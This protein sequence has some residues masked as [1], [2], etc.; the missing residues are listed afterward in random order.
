MIFFYTIQTDLSIEFDVH[1]NKIGIVSVNESLDSESTANN[2]TI[3]SKLD[4]S[5]QFPNS[6]YNH[7]KY[8]NR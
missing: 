3:F 8:E 2:L 7:F 5:N 1:F 6:F 4:I